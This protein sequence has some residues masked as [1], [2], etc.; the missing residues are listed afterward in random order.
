MSR[1]KTFT[2][3]GTLLPDDLNA[4]ED[5][6]DA[7]IATI[8]TVWLPGDLR[9]SA[10]T[11]A[12]AGWL[13]CNGQAVS[14][15]T[16]AALFAQL[17]TTEGAGDGSTSFNVP[18]LRGCFPLAANPSGVSGNPGRAIRSR[19]DAGGAETHTLTTSEMPSHDH[20]FA[21]AD[22]LAPGHAGDRVPSLVQ[23]D[24]DWVIAGGGSGSAGVN[25]QGGGQAHENM[26]P[27]RVVG[28]WFIKT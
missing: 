15:S 7:Q 22:F 8:G 23:N 21:G 28:N 25:S 2:A 3:G 20:Q 26:P 10:R 16:Y 6:I 11:A 4:I 1:V 17:G 9:Y 14:R 12:D 19:G 27:F 13:L 5:Y 24:A 18:D